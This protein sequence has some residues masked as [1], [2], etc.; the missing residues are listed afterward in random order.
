MKVIKPIRLSVL[1]KAY[2]DG[3]RDFLAVTGMV[4]MPFSEP[5]QL[6]TE[7]ALWKFEVFAGVAGRSPILVQLLQGIE[8]A[9]RRVVVLSP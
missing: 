8:V 3:P 6:V 5:A 7:P 9:R 4:L 2:S 1:Y